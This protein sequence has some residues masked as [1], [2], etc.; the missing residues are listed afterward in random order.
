LKDNKNR[1]YKAGRIIDFNEIISIS[2]KR[3]W[4]LV[5][6]ILPENMETME[7]LVGNSLPKI[8]QENSTK[9]AEYFSQKG[10]TVVNGVSLNKGEE[11]SD[12]AYPTEHYAEKGRMVVAQKIKECFSQRE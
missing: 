10:V 9:L 11:F 8:V 12:K 4:N 3:N 6:H 2:K 5:F 7:A 1:L